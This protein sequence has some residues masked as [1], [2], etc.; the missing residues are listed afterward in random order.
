[1]RRRPGLEPCDPPPLPAGASVTRAAARFEADVLGAPGADWEDVVLPGALERAVAKRR[2]SYLAGRLCAREALAGLGWTGGVPEM[3]VDR[4]PVWPAGFVGSITHTH[5][6]A[7][8][9]AARAGE[10]RGIGVDTE[11]ILDATRAE[12]LPAAITAPDVWATRSRWGLDDPAYL[13]LVFSAKESLF[14]CLYPIV[15]KFFYFQHA[16][17]DGIDAAAGT[18]RYQLLIDLDPGHPAGTTGAGTFCMDDERVHTSVM[19]MRTP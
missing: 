10:A 16:R 9:V 11:Q 14:K 2:A 3:G 13:T 15:L 4:L 5:G 18:F 12:N 1:M 7:W 6:F 17:I 19:V 8:A